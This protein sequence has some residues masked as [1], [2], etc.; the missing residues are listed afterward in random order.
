MRIIYDDDDD[1]DDE[2]FE[3]DCEDDD[4]D[5]DDEDEDAYES[6]KYLDTCQVMSRREIISDI[7]LYLKDYQPD[8]WWSCC[9]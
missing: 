8:R 3:D 4:D 2:L 6:L 1:I 7:K 5:D 9:A